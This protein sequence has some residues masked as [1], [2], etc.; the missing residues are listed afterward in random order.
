MDITCDFCARKETS[1]WYHN[2]CCLSTDPV[3][4]VANV[5]MIWHMVH[6]WAGFLGQL[7][8]S[9]ST[10]LSTAWWL[11]HSEAQNQQDLL[12]GSLWSHPSVVPL[13]LVKSKPLSVRAYAVDLS[14]SSPIVPCHLSVGVA[15]FVDCRA[16]SK[17]GPQA[18]P[19]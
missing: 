4:L 6:I 14:H 2:H 12:Y 7:L 8:R 10:F 5:Q 13:H 15:L 19:N 11:I 16:A 9:Y 18:Q 17:S 3:T 1:G